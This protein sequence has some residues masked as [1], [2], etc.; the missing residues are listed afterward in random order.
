ML[1]RRASNDKD[2]NR[3][4]RSQSAFSRSAPARP[5]FRAR[6]DAR[7]DSGSCRC[8]GRASC[9]TPSAPAA[10][11]WCRRR[12]KFRRAPPPA[13][14]RP[15]A[16]D[17]LPLRCDRR[18]ATRRRPLRATERR[19]PAALRSSGDDFGFAIVRMVVARSCALMPVVTPCAA[20]T[21]TVKSVDASRGFARP[22][23]AD[24]VAPRARS[25][26]ARKSSRGHGWP[27]VDRFA[28]SPFP[29][30]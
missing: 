29:R 4:R 1:R 10:A 15:F 12:A 23:A 13:A 18:V 11:P 9:G 5:V 14:A 2:A 27:E 20:S 25:K 19:A 26:S 24:R 28:A 7:S 30:P 17:R 21:E 3:N 6:A 22:C 16:P 8:A